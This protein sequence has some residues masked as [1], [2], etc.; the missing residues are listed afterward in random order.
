[1]LAGDRIILADDRGT[2]KLPGGCI[3]ESEELVGSSDH[4]EIKLC[5]DGVVVSG[6]QVIVELLSN[7]TVWKRNV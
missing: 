2:T 5:K 7:L 6:N 3:Y 1:M 4:V